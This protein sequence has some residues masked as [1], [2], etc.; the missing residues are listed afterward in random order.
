DEVILLPIYPAR[1]L[2]MEGVNSEML[3]NNMRLT[4]KQVLSKTELLD[5]VK[6]NKPSLLV[7]AGAGDIDTLVNPAA[8]LLMN[9]PLV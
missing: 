5:W 7:M 1:E 4:N 2:P 6:V 3:L 9:H 8:A